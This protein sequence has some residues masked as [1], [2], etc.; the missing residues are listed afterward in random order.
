MTNEKKIVDK[1]ATTTVLPFK[2]AVR[3][4][5]NNLIAQHGSSFE[6]LAYTQ[7]FRRSKLDLAPFDV[8]HR[9]RSIDLWSAL[10]ENVNYFLVPEPTTV[11]NIHY[12]GIIISIK[13][14]KKRK[15]YNEVLPQLKGFG[16]I[17]LKKIDDL[18]KWIDYC[19]KETED[20]EYLMTNPGHTDYLQYNHIERYAPKPI[21]KVRKMFETTYYKV[22]KIVDKRIL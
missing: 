15:W 9:Y 1:L 14:R 22:V 4:Q 8:Q 19:L 21:K 16:F 6:M 20:F 10:N 5:I 7:T 3:Y 17:T 12:H 13:N 11:G 2:E 18:S